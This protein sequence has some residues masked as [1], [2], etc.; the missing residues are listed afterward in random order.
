ME[1]ENKIKIN[2]ALSIFLLFVY[3]IA[4]IATCAAVWNA[5]AGVFPSVCAVAVFIVNGW[6]IYKG[7]RNIKWKDVDK[8]E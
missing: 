5:K 3:A 4:V 2:Y 6:D 7:A 1:K 8:E